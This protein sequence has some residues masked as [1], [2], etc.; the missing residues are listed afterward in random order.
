MTVAPGL[1]LWLFCFFPDPPPSSLS[2]STS[3]SSSSSC[4]CYWWQWCWWSWWWLCNAAATDNDYLLASDVTQMGRERR[5]VTCHMFGGYPYSLT[6]LPP[7]FLTPPAFPLTHPQPAS[8]W[9]SRSVLLAHSTTWV[10]NV[11]TSALPEDDQALP[12]ADAQVRRRISALTASRLLRHTRGTECFDAV[13]VWF[14]AFFSVVVYRP[15]DYL[16]YELACL[17]LDEEIT[18][19]MQRMRLISKVTYSLLHW[20]FGENVE[21]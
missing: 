12:L 15:A 13:R 7:P 21:N 18:A 4:C 10:H 11:Y 5:T 17:F 2:F 20:C 6:P 1:S 14:I 19:R 3:S 16:A 9:Q 8:K